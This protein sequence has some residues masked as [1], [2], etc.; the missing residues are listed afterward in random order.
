M[1]IPL[2]QRLNWPSQ[3]QVRS[4]RK[5]PA[6][7]RWRIWVGS[8]AYS[9]LERPSSWASTMA[10]DIQ[11][12]HRLREAEVE[13]GQGNTSPDRGANWHLKRP[14]NPPHINASEKFHRTPFLQTTTYFKCTGRIL[15]FFNAM[16][17]Y[18][19]KLKNIPLSFSSLGSHRGFLWQNKNTVTLCV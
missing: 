11:S 3:A 13:A 19:L 6:P 2:C 1:R 14:G 9:I 10:A 5:G 8:T 4:Q 12:H 7:F 16:M 17:N 15:F 18:F